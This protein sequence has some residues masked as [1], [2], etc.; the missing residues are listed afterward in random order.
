MQMQE[1][2][3][4][5]MHDHGNSHAAGSC[6]K[7]HVQSADQVIPRSEGCGMDRK[8]FGLPGCRLW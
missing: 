3:Q 2:M 6:E 7:E 1:R 4:A 5:W 8:G